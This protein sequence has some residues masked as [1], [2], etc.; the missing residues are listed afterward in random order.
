[1]VEQVEQ[2]EQVKQLELVEVS[3]IPVILLFLILLGYS[4]IGI[5]D[6]DI[7]VDVSVLAFEPV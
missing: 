5:F 7:T 6:L 3:V 1:M 4:S 2:V